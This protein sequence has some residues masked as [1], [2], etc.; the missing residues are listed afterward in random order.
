MSGWGIFI[1]IAFMSFEEGRVKPSLPP[2]IW[3]GGAS[4]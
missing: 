1:A 3:G 4:C 2:P